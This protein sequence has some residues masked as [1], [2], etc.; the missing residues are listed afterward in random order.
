[1]FEDPKKLTHKIN[2]ESLDP[3]HVSRPAPKEE[4]ENEHEDY[5]DTPEF[6]KS[7]NTEVRSFLVS[8]LV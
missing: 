4:G 8:R 2:P 3:N 7:L 6:R 5:E 1:M